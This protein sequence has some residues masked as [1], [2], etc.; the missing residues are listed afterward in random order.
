MADVDTA[1]RFVLVTGRTPGQ[2][3]GMHR[4]KTTDEYRE[5]VSVV[6]LHPEAL[7]VLGVREGQTLLLRTAAGEESFTVRT[8]SGLP[9]DMVFVPMGPAANTLVPPETA[10][11]GMPSFKGLAVEVI[12]Q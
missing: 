6:Q 3:R 9:R 7:S 4:G 11:C 8:D 2:T 10:G 12:P 5:A 1:R